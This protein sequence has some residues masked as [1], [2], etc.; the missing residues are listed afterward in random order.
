MCIVTKMDE[1]N[2]LFHMVLYVRE[3]EETSCLKIIHFYQ[4]EE[5]VP[6]ELEANSKNEAFPEITIDLI[7]VQNDFNPKNVAALAHHLNIPPS[8]MF[9]NCPGPNF[10][11]SVADFGTRIIS[12]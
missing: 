5:G 8:L 3:N 1:I 12:L 2:T 11:H 7:L 6:S 9:M 10:G 4:E